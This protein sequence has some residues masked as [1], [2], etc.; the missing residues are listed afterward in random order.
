[1]C[2][3]MKRIL[4]CG[5]ICSMLSGSFQV[6]AQSEETGD[7]TEAVLYEE[8]AVGEE[9]GEIPAF[10]EAVEEDGS[11]D[12]DMT[13]E[14]ASEE[15]AEEELTEQAEEVEEVAEPE[16]ITGDNEWLE[17]FLSADIAVE[18]DGVDCETLVEGYIQQCFD[19]ALP[20]GSGFPSL[21][22]RPHTD[23]GLSPSMSSI[24][25]GLKAGVKKIAAGDTSS[26][27]IY[28]TAS[29]MG[30]AKSTI[31]SESEAEGLFELIFGEDY[32]FDV[33]IEALLYDCPFELYWFD[34]TAYNP[35]TANMDYD[36]YNYSSDRYEIVLYGITFSFAVAGEYKAGTYSINTSTGQTVKTAV[37]KAKS[38]VDKYSGAANVKSRLTSYKNEICNLTDYNED[39]VYYGYDYGNPWQ[40]VWVFDG[41]A[42][43]KVV[44]EGYS[45]AFE[46]LCNLTGFSNVNCYT[47]GGWMYRT[48]SGFNTDGPH[49]WNIVT[50]DDGR[51]YIADITNCD[52]NTGTQ[53]F[54]TGYLSGSLLD[55]YVYRVDSTKF[56]YRYDDE[57]WEIYTPKDLTMSR[58]AYGKATANYYDYPSVL[59]MA[60]VVGNRE[61]D[62]IAMDGG[63]AGTTGLSKIME[64]FMIQVVDPDTGEMLDPDILGVEYSGHVQNVGWEK[65]VR[66][67]E[68]CGRPGKAL[69]IEAITM[70]LTGKLANQ[71]D[72][73]YCMHCQNYGWLAWAK[74]GEQAGTAGLSLRVEAIRIEIREKGEE[75][76][77]NLSGWNKSFLYSPTVYYTSYV[78]GRGWQKEVTKGKL[79]GTNGESLRLEGV[80]IRISGEANLGVKYKGHVQN[81][82]WEP[83]YVTDGQVS[84]QPGKGRRIEAFM[85]E[86]TG[87]D[88]G[89]YDIYYCLHVQNFGWLAWAKNGEPAG[90]SG[91]SMRVEAYVI[92]IL[93]KGSARPKNLGTQ[94]KAFVD[95]IGATSLT[96]NRKTATISRGGKVTLT[97]TVKPDNRTFKGVA[98]KSSNTAVATVSGGV[99]TGKSRGTAVITCTS[100]DGRVK[101]TCTVTVR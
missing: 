64:A 89:K 88:K 45:K 19:E 30:V 38:I 85:L 57:M 31:F 92:K 68:I 56:S 37:N 7:G 43:T 80:K 101:A 33:L 23:Y 95:G 29:Q 99:V 83:A 87:K 60:K 100:N 62:S 97:A 81:V 3:K 72:I 78:E 15:N 11:P 65:A 36:L 55:D 22:A 27:K 91:V 71:Y 58:Q 16:E 1:M 26:T 40:L 69:R 13:A 42:G 4:V 50:M 63:Q 34:K 93:P 25:A 12:S 48:A 82:G 21:N 86:L 66:N 74:N 76:P 51:N 28:L 47:V 24:L 35:V 90:S 41:K 53:P 14:S 44:C 77:E 61:W 59:Y 2:K 32:S 94:T 67:G 49:M 84:G 5:L 79:S 6:L 17:G 75:P 98:W 96:L 54:L 39:A 18:D 20:S 9:P 46:Y 70:K 8:N 10:E 52:N 73:Y